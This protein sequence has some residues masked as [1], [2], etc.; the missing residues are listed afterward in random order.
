MIPLAS[1]LPK[2]YIK[3]WGISKKAWDEYRKSK[4]STSRRKS[5]VKKVR[6]LARRRRAN[7]RRRRRRTPRTI[8]VLKLVSL[9]P[10]IIRAV[11]WIKD[12]LAAGDFQG[13]AYN[14]AY[15]LLKDFAGYDLNENRF[16][17]GNMLSTYGTIAAAYVGSKIATM[18]GVNR[19]LAR[20]PSPLNK[21]RL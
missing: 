6:N 10:P 7:S 18:L 2:S 13:V 19:V 16:T 5:T 17:G 15:S 14:G 11:E 21:V 9:A 4:R 12:P 1:G 3:R 20:L 8:P